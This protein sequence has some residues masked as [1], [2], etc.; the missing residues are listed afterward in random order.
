MASLFVTKD[1]K[2]PEYYPLGMRTNVIGRDEAVPIQ[3]LDD[4]ISRKHVQIH[5]NKDKK[6]FFAADMKSKNGV[7]VNG[8]KITQETPLNEG[9]EIKIGN[10]TLTFMKEDFPDKQSALNKF[11]KAGERRKS[12]L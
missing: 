5:Y 2:D 1:Q 3:V 10:T 12:T 6:M 11:K 7:L 9:D 4:Q 8:Q